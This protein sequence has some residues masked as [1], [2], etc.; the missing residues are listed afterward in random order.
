[1]E[2]ISTKWLRLNCVDSA[3]TVPSSAQYSANCSIRNKLRRPNSCPSSVQE[4]RSW[5]SNQKVIPLF[6]SQIMRQMRSTSPRSISS[7]GF[8]PSNASFGV[9]IQSLS[10]DESMTS[11][12][13]WTSRF[14]SRMERVADSPA[15]LPL[16]ILARERSEIA[17]SRANNGR[18]NCSRLRIAS[19]WP[20]RPETSSYGRETE[21][22]E[23]G[24]A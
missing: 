2:R 12:I 17:I 9:V 5:G 15:S 14:N 24:I 10:I 4:D 20:R 8:R 18:F 19:C 23:S 16:S 3:D 13:A 21:V 6:S 22:A 1:M 7:I 11:A